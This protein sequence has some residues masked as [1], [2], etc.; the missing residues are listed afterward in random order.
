[1]GSRNKRRAKAL[2]CTLAFHLAAATVLGL[3]GIEFMR[4]LPPKVI[5]ITLTGG[6][7]G[8]KSGEAPAP[9]G[10]DIS[11]EKHETE[12]ARFEDIFGENIQ[13]REKPREKRSTTSSARH[14]TSSGQGNVAS[15][16][17]GDSE[18]S[19]SG[20]GKSGEG[21]GSDGGEGNGSG[22]GFG[23]GSGV[24]ITAPVVLSSKKPEYPRSARE[25]EIEGV[26]YV[27]LSVDTAGTVIHAE[28]VSSAGYAAL[29]RAAVEAAYQWR[30]SP[31]LDRY[32]QPSPCRITI[33]FNFYLHE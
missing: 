25:A 23:E 28:V 6:G 9:S 17:S 21:N 2:A 29:D 13:N 31:A 8:G 11:A 7:G 12:P 3:V 32:G 20:L 15:A 14:S 33:P 5:E 1:M 22:E 24:A 27:A 19:G 18:G 30:F 10:E 4:R 26:A 16:G